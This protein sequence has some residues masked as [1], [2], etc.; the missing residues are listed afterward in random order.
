M[1]RLLFMAMVMVMMMMMMMM[2]MVMMVTEEKKVNGDCANSDGKVGEAGNGNADNG[3]DDADD[4]MWDHPLVGL[5]RRFVTWA[6]SPV[7]DDI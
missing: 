5:P 3:D 1:A 6:G 7:V 4:L 2:M